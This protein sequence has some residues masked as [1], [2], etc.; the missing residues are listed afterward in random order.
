MT[1]TDVSYKRWI[2]PVCQKIGVTFTKYIPD[3]LDHN[4]KV[5]MVPYRKDWNEN[6]TYK[7]INTGILTDSEEIIV[8][9]KFEFTC[10]CCY[11]E[12]ICP[13]SYDL[14]NLDGDCLESK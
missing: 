6:V 13:C 11:L 12:F 2:C 14:Y 4:P 5:K 7:S 3:C 1:I 9:H 10:F 8:H